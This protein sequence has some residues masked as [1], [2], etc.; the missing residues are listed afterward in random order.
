ML[1][2]ICFTKVYQS[3]FQSTKYIA[4]QRFLHSG[5]ILAMDCTLLIPNYKIYLKKRKKK[6]KSKVKLKKSF[7]ELFEKKEQIYLLN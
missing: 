1:N 3:C 5:R 6:R 7:F 2:L 4:G